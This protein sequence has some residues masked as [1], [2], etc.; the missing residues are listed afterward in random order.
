MEL[1][2][3]VRNHGGSGGRNTYVGASV[4]SAP[5]AEHLE[6]PSALTSMAEF[7]IDAAVEDPV[8][9]LHD[10]VRDVFGVLGEERHGRAIYFARS[11]SAIKV[12]LEPG[13][14]TPLDVQRELGEMLALCSPKV[15]ERPGRPAIYSPGQSSS[16]LVEAEQVA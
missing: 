15:R 7:R 2:V 14:D 4:G 16:R 8:G 3:Y 6:M 11:R 12:L 10:A 5:T 9:E 1:L 13:F